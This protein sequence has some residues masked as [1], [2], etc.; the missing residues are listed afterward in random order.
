[1]GFL[2]IVN[3]SR[4]AA[5]VGGEVLVPQP[6]HQPQ[7][8]EATAYVVI[9]IL[10]EVYEPGV[11]TLP[12][13]ARVADAVEMAGGYTREA[14][15]TRINLAVPLRD[16]MQ[17]IVPAVGDYTVVGQGESG[18]ASANPTQTNSD[19]IDLNAASLAQLQ[20]L[21]GIGPARAQSIIDYRESIGGFTQIEELLNISG[22][23]NAIFNGLKELITVR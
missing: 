11:Y 12:A 19:I 18:I 5:R 1:M 20:S 17:I 6:Q 7:P 15:L 4:P 10:G 2:F 3:P 21:P 13:S 22:I 9:H 8:E 16:A 23:G 14:D